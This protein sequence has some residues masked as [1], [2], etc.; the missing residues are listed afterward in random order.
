MM[1]NAPLALMTLAILFA[2]GCREIESG[3]PSFH[4]AT[5]PVRVHVGFS[6]TEMGTS[7]DAKSVA[8]DDVEH[9]SDAYLFAFLA[10]G[11]G[12]GEPCVVNGAPA[13]IHTG[14]KSFEWTLPADVQI[15]VMAVVNA[16]PDI[17][18]QLNAW[19]GGQAR[20]SKDNLLALQSI[21]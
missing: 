17:R 19:A 8:S 9:F 16:A 3:S 10:S 20:F 11:T 21:R 5:K 2:T 6:S 18:P 4:E 15:E 7:V 12:A 14:T 1:N 13:A